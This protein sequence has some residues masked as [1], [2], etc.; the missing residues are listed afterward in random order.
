MQRPFVW[1]EDRITRLIDSLLRGFPLGT[2]LLWKT[3]TMQR[4]RRFQRDI[5]SDVLE[6]FKFEK[7]ED[8]DRYL[9]LDGQQRLTS[10]LSALRG[11]YNNKRVFL[12]VLSGD[13]TDKDPGDEY[14][15]S[16]FLTDG[17]VLKLNDTSNG[18][19]CYYIPLQELTKVEA[20]YA[21]T[22]AFEKSQKLGLNAEQTKQITN[23]YLRCATIMGGH[24]AL[25]VHLIDENEVN[26][27]PLEEILEIFVRVNSGGLVLQKSDLLMS[28][29]DLKWNDIQPHLQLLVRELNSNKPFNFTRDDILKEPSHRSWFGD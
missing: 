14:Y 27:T 28:L 7:A 11:T 17:E 20:V 4:Y 1:K 23:T 8:D 9:V 22:I 26:V 12:D 13:S 19:S 3:K 24:R 6:V 18:V 15:D 29:L 16:R 10:L 5:D 25:Q 21:A 2:I